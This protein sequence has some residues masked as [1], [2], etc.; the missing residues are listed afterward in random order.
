MSSS[1]LCSDGCPHLVYLNISWCTNI[2]DDGL[3]TLAMGC[4]KLTSFICKGCTQVN[5]LSLSISKS[6]GLSAGKDCFVVNSLTLQ[7][8]RSFGKEHISFSL[9]QQSLLFSFQAT[10]RGISAIVSRNRNLKTL[11]I[12]SCSVSVL[13]IVKTNP[14][15]LTFCLAKK[16]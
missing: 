12:H 10:D 6:Q 3:V 13:H 1:S 9:V 2:T 8:S 11:N 15:T 14:T 7:L 4:H 5:T 16:K